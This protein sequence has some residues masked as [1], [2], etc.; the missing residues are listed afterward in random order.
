MKTPYRYNTGLARKRSA[1]VT[2]RG[3]S[4]KL[5]TNGYINLMLVTVYTDCSIMNF[6]VNDEEEQ[7]SDGRWMG[8]PASSTERHQ[9]FRRRLFRPGVEM[10]SAQHSRYAIVKC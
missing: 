6:V 3:T 1:I 9:H 8:I 4:A 10:P 2:N 7:K 5:I